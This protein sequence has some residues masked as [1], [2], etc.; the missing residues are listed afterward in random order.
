MIP[1][2]PRANF[3]DANGT[4]RFVGSAPAVADADRWTIDVRHNAGTR[5]RFQVFYGSQLVRWSSP[6]HRATASRDS[7][8]CHTREEHPDDQRDA[9]VRRLRLLNEARFGRSRLVGGTFPAAALN[10]D[11]LRHRERGHAPD[12]PAA[13][14][15]GGRSQLRRPRHPPAG[16][17][18]YVVCLVNDTFSR[19]RG[20]HS[21]TASAA[22]TG[23]SS[24]RTSPRAPACSTFRAWM[25]SWLERRMPSTSRS[26]SGRASSTST[27]WGSSSQDRITLS[28]SL[29]LDLGMRYE[30]HVTPTERDN[31]FV[32]FDAASASL[33]RV[34]VD[35]DRSISRTIETSSRALGVA[36]N[37]SADGRTVLRAAY[38]RRSTSRA[39]RRSAT[40]PAIRPSRRRSRRPARFPS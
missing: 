12:R 18:R 36:W 13:D 14:D 5:D 28:N 40:P 10:P 11:G 7:A 30:W 31:Q 23:I 33:L 29:T 37:L 9:H 27:P 24:T 19:A 26:V 1:L 6:A 21:M 4:P 8:A 20:R 17:K 25:P 35:V 34:G 22:S 39:R 2:I 38:G 3:F 15:R 16:P 32:V